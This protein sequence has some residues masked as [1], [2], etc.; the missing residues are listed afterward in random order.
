MY[1]G[2]KSNHGLYTDRRKTDSL[3]VHSDTML[4]RF[5]H[6]F[7][8]RRSSSTRRMRAHYLGTDVRRRKPLLSYLSSEIVKPSRRRVRINATHRAITLPRHC[9]L[10][11]NERDETLS[12]LFSPMG[13]FTTIQ[14]IAN[15][16]SY[17]RTT[18]CLCVDYTCD[19]R[20]TDRS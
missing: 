7:V 9:Y 11:A 2:V 10:P 16:L 13:Y 19:T 4:S 15:G 5:T 1:G 14:Q 3:S 12:T 6:S 20:R 17:Q 18:V 8:S